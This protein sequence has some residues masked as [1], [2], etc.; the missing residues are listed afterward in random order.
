MEESV[1]KRGLTA[2]IIGKGGVPVIERCP[3]RATALQVRN[4]IES[5]W[6]LSNGSEDRANMSLKQVTGAKGKFDV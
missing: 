3:F 2:A 5:K 1:Y 4:S 6:R